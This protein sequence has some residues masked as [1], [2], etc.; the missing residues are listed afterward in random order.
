MLIEC[1]ACHA[2][3]KLPD[4]KEGA[5]VRCGECGRVYLAV[6]AGQRRSARQSSGSNSGMII[7]IG[8]AV[9]G[10]VFLLIANNLTGGDEPKETA[11]KEEEVEDDGPAHDPTGWYS[12]IV[13]SAVAIHTAAFALNEDKLVTM[14]DAPQLWARLQALETPEGQ[15]LP[16]PGEFE[17]LPSTERQLFLTG[18][19]GSL[20]QGENK[21]LI[22]D[23]EPF[24][25][26]VIEETDDTATVRL[27][28]TARAEG[29]IT[30]RWVEWKLVKR[31]KNWKAWSWERW[32]SPAEQAAARKRARRNKGYEK[33][34]L[35]DGSKVLEREPEPL[36]HLDD[37][38]QELR[39]RIDHLYATM[40]DLELTKE[41]SAASTE[42]VE[43]G[44]PAIPILLTGLYETPLD[45]Q[46]QSIQV[47]M[48]VVAL[49]R[50]TGQYFGYKPQELV[51]S[52]VGTSKE[53]R[54]SAIKQWFAWWF[55]NQ[56]KFEEKELADGLEGKI[57]L[58]DR[59]KAFLDREDG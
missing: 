1:P 56:D 26:S 3:A 22:G 6:P 36:A 11:A 37:T 23:W 51:G 48:M 52:G 38:P 5:K 8:A 4:S 57:K 47:N 55:R 28:V 20:I 44:R 49:R 34:V 42:L 18:Q 16:T 32:L 24:D 9:V 41:S 53:R 14:L 21:A 12:D 25:G 50:I 58:T 2:R 19:A 59:E 17:L 46:D 40:I 10:V 31:G 54:E 13:Q 30:K 35:S 33:V 39:D 7:G 27:Q 15:P 45:T 43:I 29:D